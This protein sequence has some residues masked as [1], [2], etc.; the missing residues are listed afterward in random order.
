MRLLDHGKTVFTKPHNALGV[1]KLVEVDFAFEGAVEP[2]LDDSLR[3]VEHD[4]QAVA[5][6][7]VSEAGGIL[8]DAPDDHRPLGQ[9]VLVEARRQLRLAKRLAKQQAGRYE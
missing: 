3:R 7:V 8:A 5:P 6:G 4:E 2:K 1:L 9:G